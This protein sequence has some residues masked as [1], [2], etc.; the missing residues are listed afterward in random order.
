[1]WPHRTYQNG[2]EY[3]KAFGLSQSRKTRRATS[4]TLKHEL[5]VAIVGAGLMGHWHLSAARHAGSHVV[6][7]I[8]QD[9]AAAKALAR[10]APS[11][12]AATNIAEA[13]SSCDL[14]VAHVCT[15]VATHF[16]IAICLL[17]RGIHL[18]VEKPLAATS[19]EVK[20]LVDVAQEQGVHICPVHQYA[21][22]T[23]FEAART[24]LTSLGAIRRLDFNICSAGAVASFTN[25]A[26]DVVAE[27]LPHPLSMLQKLVPGCSVA[28]IH[29]CVVRTLSGEMMITGCFDSTLATICVSLSSRPT[30]FTVRLQC[31]DGSI[32]IDGF[33]GYSIKLSGK[34]SRTAKMLSPFERSTKS[35]AI[36]LANLTR[37]IIRNELAYP[38]L[39]SLV[40]HFYEAVQ[41]V[42]PPPF[43]A[44]EIFACAVARDKIMREMQRAGAQLTG[45]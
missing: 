1:M 38:G 3:S 41:D 16:P 6:A 18:L 27:I 19:E 4:G 14:D 29:W 34:V 15:P 10:L 26:D 33:H 22:Q 43:T 5:K 36:G 28:G 24:H 31:T 8:D 32:E 35:L 30:G 7:I 17:Q 9:L 25:R 45:V 21:C 20:H 23:G 39:R 37:R 44:E 40:N 2:S 13:L 11:A 12:V 42:A